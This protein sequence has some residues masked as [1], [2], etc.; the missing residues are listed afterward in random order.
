MAKPTYWNKG[1]LNLKFFQVVLTLFYGQ[2]ISNSIF[3]NFIITIPELAE[4]AHWYLIVKVIM[5]IIIFATSIF[6]LFVVWLRH[7]RLI[8]LSGI[9]LLFVF[10]TTIVM[11]TAMLTLDYEKK[12]RGEMG[13]LIAEVTVESVFQLIGIIA[14]FFMASRR[15][16]KK[17]DG[18][19]GALQMAQGD[20]EEDADYRDQVEEVAGSKQR[21]SV[22][23]ARSQVSLARD[24]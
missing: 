8:F 21:A 18:G 10:V 1:H 7:F 14:T 12:S 13:K 20:L 19:P 11:T 16:Y 23:K 9:I 17:G 4:E 5:G 6:S 15:E 22:S 24:G 3:D 2:Y